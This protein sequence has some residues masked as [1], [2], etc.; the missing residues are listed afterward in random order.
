MHGMEKKRF[1]LIYGYLN[2][3][4]FSY[5][6]KKTCMIRSVMR[7]LCGQAQNQWPDQN[8]GQITGI[9]SSGIAHRYP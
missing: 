4:C 3:Y 9:S 2:K 5:S 6:Q 7:I 1:Y 8:Y